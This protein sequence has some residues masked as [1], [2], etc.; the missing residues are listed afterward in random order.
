[1]KTEPEHKKHHRGGFTLVELLIV[2]VI[3]AILAA[4]VIPQFTV[5]SEDAKDAV[6]RQNL[7][8]MRSQIELF[9]AQHGGMFPGNGPDPSITFLQHMAVYSDEAGGASIFPGPDYP[10]GP[11]FVAHQPPRNPF[12]GGVQVQDSSNPAGE[13]PDHTLEMDGELVG[14]F[15]DPTTGRLAPNAEGT[16][17]DGTPR[18][19]Y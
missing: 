17:A 2:V 11:Y 15:Y 3:L 19:S 16:G 10:L 12:N 4:T 5:S 8:V 18:I 9:R 13:T 6:L 1:M 7:Q 14:W